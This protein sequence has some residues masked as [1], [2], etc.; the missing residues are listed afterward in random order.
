MIYI[1]LAEFDTTKKILDFLSNWY[2]TTCLAHYYQL[3]TTLNSLKQKSGYSITYFL[4]I[5]QPIWNQLTQANIN[6]Y[7]LHFIQVLMHLYLGYKIE[8]AAL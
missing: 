3:L 6:N 1:Q 4:S 7:H 2:K 8:R 5:I